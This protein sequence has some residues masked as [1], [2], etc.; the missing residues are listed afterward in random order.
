MW[1]YWWHTTYMNGQ[2]EAKKDLANLFAI[3][4]FLTDSFNAMYQEKYDII[5]KN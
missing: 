3:V 2:E 5:Y 4:D 1:P